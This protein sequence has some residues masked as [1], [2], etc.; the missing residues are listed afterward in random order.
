MFCIRMNIVF[1]HRRNNLL[2]LPC[3]TSI[4]PGHVNK[5]VVVVVVVVV[6]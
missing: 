5:V 6:K 4:L 3:K 2:F 1:C